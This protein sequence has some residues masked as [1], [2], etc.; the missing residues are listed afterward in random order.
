MAHAFA[1]PVLPSCVPAQGCADLIVIDSQALV[2]AGLVSLIQAGLKD[3]NVCYAGA[4]AHE[5][6]RAAQANPGACVVIC[7]R[8][9]DTAGSEIET[10]T[11]FTR[12]GIPV[13]VL[14]D[15]P[16]IEGMEA[17]LVAGAR[18]YLGKDLD[19]QAFFNALSDLVAGRTCAST[20]QVYRDGPRSSQVHIS[21]QERRALIL[22]SSGLTQDAVARRMGIAPSTVK[23]YLDR[24]RAKY[25]EIGIR[26]R[27][28]LELH[29]IARSEG[30][31]P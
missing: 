17:A 16:S 9:Y 15:H 31:L 4:S 20:T 7:T 18:G 27:T 8:R 26:A 13:L 10:V 1:S 6:L 23:H 14:V 12:H 19:S 21:N 22:Y 2:R 3:V 28:K 29:A 25:E 5:G 30:L 11:A 24:V